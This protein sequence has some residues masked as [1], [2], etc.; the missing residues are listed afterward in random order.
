MPVIRIFYDAS[1]DKVMRSNRTR[2]QSDIE[3]VMQETLAADLGNCQVVMCV[4][5]LST[6]LP[7]Y[8]DLQFRANNHRTHAV[9]DEAIKRLAVTIATASKSGV[10]IR[11][12]D[13]DQSSLHHFDFTQEAGNEG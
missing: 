4:A 13:I 2:I 12:F 11:A 10:R 1:L 6:P 3:V 5:M 7:I 8:V 9:V